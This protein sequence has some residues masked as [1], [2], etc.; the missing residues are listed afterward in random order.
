MTPEMLQARLSIEITALK[1]LRDLIT[2]MHP[3]EIQDHLEN[4]TSR[5]TEIKDVISELDQNPS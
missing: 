1:A 3:T 2:K 4:L 5:L